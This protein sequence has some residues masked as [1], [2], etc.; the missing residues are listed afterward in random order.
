MEKL[1]KSLKPTDTG[2]VVSSF[3]EEN[4]PT[5]ISDSFTAEMENELDE[6][7][8]GERTYEKTLSE[9]YKPFHKEVKSKE[10]TAKITNLGAADPKFVCPK[11]GTTPMD[12]KL[13]RNG[14]FISCSKYPDCDG[15]LTLDGVEFKKDEP[16]GVDPVSG[17]PIF[18]LNGRFGPYVQ[19][20][21][22]LPKV[23]KVRIKKVKT[24]KEVLTKRPVSTSAEVAP[25]S[26][27][28]SLLP[29]VVS[30]EHSDSPSSAITTPVKPRMASIPKTMDPSKVTVE[31]A[32]KYLS[33]PRTLGVDPK[34]GKDIVASAG[35]F[36]PYIVSDGNYRSIKMPDDV[37][38]ITLERALEMLA[39]P[40]A[41]RKGPPSNKFR[42]DK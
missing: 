14:K 7:A 32:M 23:K 1:N 18:V 10:K 19:L 28:P 34:T 22:K 12:I 21:V 41:V 24:Q 39:I 37:Y 5:Y 16:I 17:L 42:R 15:A 30:T 26:P 25:R 20:G 3:L 6:I 29:K 27:S 8:N 38:E 9:F 35:R 33:L 11:C 40:K 13:G 31:D 36:G 4:F 2:D